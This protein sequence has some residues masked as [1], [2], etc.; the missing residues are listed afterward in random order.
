[1]PAQGEQ[2]IVGNWGIQMTKGRVEQ[3]VIDGDPVFRIN[4]PGLVLNPI[5][6]F[7]LIQVIFLLVQCIL[8][9]THDFENDP[10]SGDNSGLDLCLALNLGQLFIFQ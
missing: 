5:F 1:V 6:M 4:Q 8:F 10:E 7:F 2:E 3:G 9:K